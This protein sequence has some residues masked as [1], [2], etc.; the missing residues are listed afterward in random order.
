MIW[1]MPTTLGRPKTLS[2]A[3]LDTLLTEYE[4]WIENKGSVG[5]FA[6]IHEMKESQLRGRL[7]MARELRE[8]AQPDEN[9]PLQINFSLGDVWQL[10]GNWTIIGDVHA[11]FT[12]LPTIKRMLAITRHYMPRPR[13]LLLAGD[14]FNMDTFSHYPSVVNTPSFG[15]ERNYIKALFAEWLEVYDEIKMIM[16]NHDR[17]IQKF[18]AG[19]FEETDI[20]ALVVSNPKKVQISNYGYCNISASGVNWRVTHPRNYSRQ[21]LNVAGKLADLKN[22]NVISFHEHHL[23]KSYSAGGH[24]VVN[25][26]CAVDASKLA[27][28][29][30]DDGLSPQMQ[31]GF[32][33]LR[34]GYA[35]EWGD[36]NYTD[37]SKW[38]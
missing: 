12:H 35:Q 20:L 21:P 3:Y 30:L 19:A 25:G 33:T 8:A 17:R 24:V 9:N 23:G 16:G 11:P 34:D 26:G 13:R 6:T 5:E 18:T 14:V 2:E 7:Q 27:Y 38:I 36:E 15:V 22:T 1:N 4:V 29:I 31:N 37:W 10:E 28:V 32:V